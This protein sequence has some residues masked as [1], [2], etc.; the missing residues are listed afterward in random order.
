MSAQWN[1]APT[2]EYPTELPGYPL[3]EPVT[4]FPSAMSNTRAG[5]PAKR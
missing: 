3:G 1:D 2:Q 4:P 5:K